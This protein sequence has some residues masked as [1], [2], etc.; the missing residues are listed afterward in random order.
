MLL[1]WLP[2][3]TGTSISVQYNKPVF[4]L[5]FSS[6]CHSYAQMINNPLGQSCSGQ[7]VSNVPSLAMSQWHFPEPSSCSQHK[8]ETF[9]SY[10]TGPCQPPLHCPH[11]TAHTSVHSRATPGQGRLS[12]LIVTSGSPPSALPWFGQHLNKLSAAK[13]CFHSYSDKSAN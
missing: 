6:S 11:F 3:C 7:T 4:W 13:S 9:V 2:H 12:L 8:K 1:G 5:M 10:E